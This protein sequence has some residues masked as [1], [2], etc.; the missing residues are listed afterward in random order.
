MSMSVV[1]AMLG[2]GVLSF[3]N[4]CVLPLLPVWSAISVAAAPE[5]PGQV[6]R[7]TLPF[8]A[9]L[10]A[11]F[12]A[13]GASAGALGGLFDPSSVW[14]P[15]FGGIVLIVFGVLLLG[16]GPAWTRRERRLPVHLPERSGRP[17]AG[18]WRGLVAGVVVGAAWTPCAGPLLGAALV[19]AASTGGAA[20]GAGLLGVYAVGV[21]VPFVAAALALDAWPG[22]SARVARHAGLARAAGG[23]LLILTGGA[24]AVGALDRLVSPAASLLAG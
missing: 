7:A 23:A 24:L 14:L 16:G 17:G 20:L 5:R 18:P 21:C 8:V 11:T 9:G 12:S 6:L 22:W 13:L 19:A 1:L 3:A 4:P 2:A 10:A 15:R